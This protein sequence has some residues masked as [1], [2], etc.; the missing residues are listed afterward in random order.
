[1]EESNE[2]QTAP[3]SPQQ[4]SNEVC[5]AAG[6][7]EL[8]PHHW[9][10]SLE[11]EDEKIKGEFE[12]CELYE[13][14]QRYDCTL[15]YDAESS[16]K[17]TKNRSEYRPCR[18]TES[19]EQLRMLRMQLICLVIGLF[20]I[21][22]VKRQKVKSASLFDQ[23]RARNQ[24]HNS[25]TSNGH[26]DAGTERRVKYSQLTKEESME[27]IELSWTRGAGKV[28]KSPAPGLQTV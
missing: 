2:G 20:S 15:F 3:S 17:T 1:M 9:R 24:L 14:R 26:N 12:S 19:D 6:E 22:M 27:T 21:R 18:Y 11:T 4:H 7:C 5:S 28:P 13:R 8:C 16:E 23:R 10:V 25:T